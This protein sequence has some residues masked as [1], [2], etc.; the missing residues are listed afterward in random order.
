MLFS[1]FVVIP[2]FNSP[3]RASGPPSLYHHTAASRPSIHTCHCQSHHH[4]H[5]HNL[6]TIQFH[7]PVVPAA[8]VPSPATVALNLT[9]CLALSTLALAISLSFSYSNQER[10]DSWKLALETPIT[11]LI[12]YKKTFTSTKQTNNF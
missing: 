10:S 3:H 4:T 7:C 9:L 8:S 5:P 2:L 12:I 1:F 6:A 11:L